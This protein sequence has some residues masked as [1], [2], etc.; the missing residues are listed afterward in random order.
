MSYV[1]P[2][3]VVGK[4]TTPSRSE[5]S[6]P[7]LNSIQSFQL[8]STHRCNFDVGP[9]NMFTLF[10]LLLKSGIFLDRPKSIRFTSYISYPER[11]MT[12]G[13]MVSSLIPLLRVEN[14]VFGCVI[15]NL[16]VSTGDLLRSTSDNCSNGN[17]QIK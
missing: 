4:E 3:F 10:E 9:Q 14:T 16:H 2:V 7:D 1:S 15:R 12:S 5:L 13:V 11:P 6:I 8:V 17:D